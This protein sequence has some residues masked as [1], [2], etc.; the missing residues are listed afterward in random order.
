M[1]NI[2]INPKSRKNLREFAALIRS[3][4]GIKDTYIDVIKFL[5]I[6]MCCYFEKLNIEIV[7]DFC[8]DH[9]KCGEFDLTNN[10]IRIKENVYELANLHDG[11]SR[12]DIMHECAHKLLSSIVNQTFNRKVGKVKVYENPEWQADCLAAELLMPYEI[13]KDK[14]AEEV[15]KMCGVSKKAA[16]YQLSKIREEQNKCKEE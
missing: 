11:R 4:F 2:V 9:N 5:E 12:Y 10:T 13:I 1:N 7:E 15:M 16:E 8:N 3:T 6:S 14:T